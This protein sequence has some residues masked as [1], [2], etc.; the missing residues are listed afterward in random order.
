MESSQSHQPRGALASPFGWSR[1]GR[2]AGR[3]LTCLLTTLHPERALSNALVQHLGQELP[4]M[5]FTLES[6]APDVIWVCGF[7]SGAEDLIRGLRATH[8]DAFVVVTGRGPVESWE[9]GV[10]DAG[11][12]FSCGW[13]L[14]VEEL[15][16]ILDPARRP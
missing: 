16:R 6:P 13:P 5:R 12:D 3:R 8:P 4:D 14:P 10:R 11:A 1:A 15:A 2:T 7:E 9:A